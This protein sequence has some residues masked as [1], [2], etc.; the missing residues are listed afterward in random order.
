MESSNGLWSIIWTSKLISKALSM[1]Y[2]IHTILRDLPIMDFN[3][4]EKMILYINMTSQVRWKANR[5]GDILEL[6]INEN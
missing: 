5:Y 4:D 1:K 2:Y 6:E 3:G